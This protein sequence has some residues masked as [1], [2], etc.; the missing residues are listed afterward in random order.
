MKL[1]EIYEEML[2]R[3]AWNKLEEALNETV[4]LEESNAKLSALLKESNGAIF[5]NFNISPDNKKYFVAGSAR[6]YLYP[7][8]VE[9]INDVTDEMDG[10]SGPVGPKTPTEPGDLDIVI[11]SDEDWEALKKN[12][13]GKVDME[14]FDKNYRNRI[15]RPNELGLT[16]MDIESFDAWAPSRA[17]GEYSD[18]KVDSTKNILSR[19]TKFNGYYFMNMYDVINY[20]FQMGRAKDLKI[21]ELI[22]NY[23]KR[24]ENRSKEDLFKIISRIIRMRYNP[25]TSK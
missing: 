21:A 12:M 4:L 11:P 20:K 7:G 23:I 24:R 10:T 8:L 16:N 2:I 22:N 15:F 13:S 25:T 17:G 9:F 18:T 6:L 1:S 19:A 5:E 14:K 3:D